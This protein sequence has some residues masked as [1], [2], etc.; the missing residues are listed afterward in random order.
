M[1]PAAPGS[2][3]HSAP[4]SLCLLLLVVSALLLLALATYNPADPSSNTAG[5]IPPARASHL[6]SSLEAH[7]GAQ[8]WTG[9]AG[10][11]VAD[12]ILQTI[13]IAAFFLPILLV[14]V[15]ICWMRQ[16]TAGS[17]RARV[18]GLA[19]W[20]IF[21]PA[22]I[23]LLPHRILWHSALPIEGVTGRLLADALISYLNL[24]G[25]TIVLALMVAILFRV[26]WQ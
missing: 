15:G 17:T 20:V 14:R 22:A 8:N 21:A 1:H 2:R 6:A 7:L 24:P 23:G 12:L 25:A 9:V 19:L 18:L 4:A 13:G 26:Y 10:A 3:T 5:A 11:W 16:R